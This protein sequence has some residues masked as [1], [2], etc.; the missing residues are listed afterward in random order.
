M[1]LTK[2]FVLV[3]MHKRCAR[4]LVV[5][6]VNA[7]DQD[8]ALAEAKLIIEDQPDLIKAFIMEISIEKL[9]LHEYLVA[10]VVK[11]ANRKE[12]RDVVLSVKA[13]NRN[14]ASE[15]AEKMMEDWKNVIWAEVIHVQKN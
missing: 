8:D 13:R 10:A 6:P 2:F 12:F 14:E 1:T 9:F 4:K 3:D 15:Y 7:F 5:I 11:Y